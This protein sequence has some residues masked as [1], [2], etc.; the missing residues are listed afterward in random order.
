M[1]TIRVSVREPSM[2]ERT[3][4]PRPGQRGSTRLARAFTGLAVMCA[5]T[6]LVGCGGGSASPAVT[7]SDSGSPTPS[8]PAA[9]A[10]T[11]PSAGPAE[12]ISGVEVT[13]RIAGFQRPWDLRF[14][15]DGTP[16]VTERSGQLAVIVDGRRQLVADVPDVVA[17]GEGGLMGL[18]L[19]PRFATNR[20]IYLCHAAGAGHTVNDVR[21]VRYRLAES[22][23]GISDATPIV[24]GLPA[25]AGNRHLGCRVDVGPDGMLWITA[26]DAVT[27]TAPQ[28]PQSRGGKVLR[29]TLAGDPA[30][31]NPGGAWDPYVYTLGHRNV[32]GLS[33]RPA[34]EAPFSV[35]HGTGCDDEINLLVAGGNYGWNPIGAG[36]A[37]PRTPR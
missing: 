27:P 21:V 18:A 9:T 19:D 25:G 15:P 31:D 26:G 22:L 30:P 29:A 1:V 28:D 37:T 14:L 7:P 23:D 17:S 11:S 32:Q 6:L 36:G 20:R 35:E 34:D 16:L 2:T 24:T 4:L 13:N 5:T 33:F 3:S 10:S 12:D 8:V